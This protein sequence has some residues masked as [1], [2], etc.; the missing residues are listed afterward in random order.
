MGHRVACPVI[1]RNGLHIRKFLNSCC[2]YLISR[3]NPKV[4]EA[5]DKGS[6]MHFFCLS[7]KWA[8][9]SKLTLIPPLPPHLPASNTTQEPTGFY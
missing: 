9:G 3:A 2:L 6:G 8:Q 5:E 4:E 1:Q 7:V